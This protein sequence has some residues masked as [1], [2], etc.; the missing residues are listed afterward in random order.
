MGMKRLVLLFAAL[1]AVVFFFAY[2]PVTV[3]VTISTDGDG[4]NDAI[5]ATRNGTDNNDTL[6]GTV[7]RDF[8][9]GRGGND[10]L[11]GG[12]GK[13]KIVGGLG[14]D[15]VY[16]GNHGD[17]ISGGVPATNEGGVDKLYG[18][19]GDDVLEAIDYGSSSPDTLDCG[20]GKGDFAFYD[21]GDTLIGCENKSTEWFA[22]QDTP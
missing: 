4:S 1:G 5:A 7:N 9:N 11:N 13:D 21:P 15:I 6:T 18:G 8:L 3:N 22:I 2:G 12:D 17:D 10:T 16:G 20:P 14:N 19:A